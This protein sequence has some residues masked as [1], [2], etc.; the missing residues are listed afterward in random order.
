MLNSFWYHC[1]SITCAS[2]VV[3]TVHM[4]QQVHFVSTMLIYFQL[5]LQNMPATQE[6]M[7]RVHKRMHQFHPELKRC[8]SA[9]VCVT[10]LFECALCKAVFVS[11]REK[12]I[13]LIFEHDKLICRGLHGCGWEGC[14]RLFDTFASQDA[15]EALGVQAVSNHAAVHLCGASAALRQAL[16]MS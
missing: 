1:F 12:R 5:H 15:H 11:H 7:P 16:N 6:G 4:S 9:R 14:Q 13:H 8:L 10:Q 3:A 2:N